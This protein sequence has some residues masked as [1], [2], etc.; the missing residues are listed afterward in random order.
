MVDP[1]DPRDA[2]RIAW[3]DQLRGACLEL[4][5]SPFD[6]GVAFGRAHPGVTAVAL[7]SSRADR[8]GEHVQAV[9]RKLPAEVW[10][11]LRE[12][13]LISQDLPLLLN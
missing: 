3:R 9:T 12:R 5:V 1:K 8:I 10:Q 7:S 6:V 4:G 11:L 2:Q 13:G